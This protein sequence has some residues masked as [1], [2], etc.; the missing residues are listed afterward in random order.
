MEAVENSKEIGDRYLTNTHNILH[1]LFAHL[2]NVLLM[3]A[4]FFFTF[5]QVLLLSGL[6]FYRKL[7]I[8]LQML[9]WTNGAFSRTIKNQSQILQRRRINLKCCKEQS[10]TI[11]S[12]RN[13]KQL[14]EFVG[15]GT[16]GHRALLCQ[17]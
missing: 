12:L 3:H 10:T 13:S 14:C 9:L 5:F 17:Q 4:I 8:Q 6:I 7:S 15:D 2:K 1:Q 16:W 11:H